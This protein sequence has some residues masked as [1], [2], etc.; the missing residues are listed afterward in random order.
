MMKRQTALAIKREIR[1]GEL[2]LKELIDKF[3]ELEE[4]YLLKDYN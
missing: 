2:S 3:Y 1:K 4:E